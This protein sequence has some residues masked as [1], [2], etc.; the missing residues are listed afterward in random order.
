M[1][2]IEVRTRTVLIF[3][4]LI[5]LLV[6][7]NSFRVPF[8]YDD[9][10]F[11]KE[12]IIIKSFPAFREWI[13]SGPVQFMSGRAFL[14]LTF[15]ANYF[16][17]GLDTFGYHVVNIAIHVA[18]AF[19]FYLLLIQFVDREED[20]RYHARSL[21]AA[22]IFLVHPINTE[23]VTYISSRSSEL[24]TL[25]L[26]ATILLFA[27]ST[28]GGFRPIGYVLSLATFLLGL[29]T[30]ISVAVA[31]LLLLLFDR[32]FLS[33][34]QDRCN[35]RLAYHLP[36][37]VILAAGAAYFFQT[38]MHPE[39]YDRPWPNHIMTELRVFV[40]YLRLLFLPLGL[41]IDH[42]IKESGSLDG[43]VLTAGVFLAAVIGTAFLLRRKYKVLS[44][45]LLW[46]LINL[47]PLMALRLNDYMAERWVYAASLGFALGISELIAML[48]GRNVKATLASGAAIVVMFGVLTIARNQAYRDPVMLWSDAVS[49]SPA[50]LRPYTNLSAAYLERGEI[51][52]AIGIMERSLAAGNDAPEVQQ[53]LAMAHF[54]NDDLERAESL[55][56]SLEGRIPPYAYYYN[57]GT[58]YKQRTLY[59]RA[60]TMF[61]HAAAAN[62]RSP[63]ALGSAG[64]CHRALG[65]VNKAEESFRAATK[66]IPQTA[67]DHLILA[68]SHFALGN[69]EQGRESLRTAMVADPFNIYL[70]NVVATS[71]LEDGHYDEAYRHYTLMTK[72]SPRFAG[73]YI[74]MGKI[75]L[76]QGNGRAART[77]FEKALKLLPPESPERNTVVTLLAAT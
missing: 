38:I 42:D 69:N 15:S 39:M 11:L 76:T 24:S 36:F 56:L 68:K 4:T 9:F 8:H 2:P 50:K 28:S 63:A 23:S 1:E 52:R 62:D 34:E 72:I 16:V 33:R 51:G 29:A 20:D 71:L 43:S 73:A 48:A 74:S 60:I 46:L 30:K 17:N 22:T 13:S 53:N 3:L 21:L 45:S 18:A 75:L 31:P 49:K 35:R 44:F 26:L 55:L 58:I 67:E 7:A 47:A 37:W 41:N 6:Y 5:G 59:R 12:Q 77:L 10:H 61:N 19:L 25:L 65:D 66:K 64:E 57:L 32:S 14:L 54:L 40:V 70:R 27:R